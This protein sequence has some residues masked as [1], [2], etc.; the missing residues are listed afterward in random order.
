MFYKNIS[1]MIPEVGLPIVEL[2]V[3]LVHYG[4]NYFDELSCIFFFNFVFVEE[5]VLIISKISLNGMFVYK[6]L[7]SNEA[8]FIS[9]VIFISFSLLASTSEFFL[10]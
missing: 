10:L 1:D 9:F 4:F 5:G 8:I 7:M 3:I 2:E 6:F